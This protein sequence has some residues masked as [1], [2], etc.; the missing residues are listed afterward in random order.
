[1]APAFTP[2]PALPCPPGPCAFSLAH[3]HPPTHPTLLL[4]VGPACSNAPNVCARPPPPPPRRTPAGSHSADSR[5]S[6]AACLP[7][8]A[9]SS[10]Q[11]PA[12]HHPWCAPSTTHPLLQ[13]AVPPPP[14][15]PSRPC[16]L[17]WW[18]CWG[19]IRTGRCSAR[20]W[21][22]C[23]AWPRHA[24]VGGWWWWG[25]GRGGVRGQVGRLWWGWGGWGGTVCGSGSGGP[26]DLSGGVCCPHPPNS[27]TAHP[28]HPAAS[29]AHAC[30]HTPPSPAGLCAAHCRGLPPS[31]STTTTTT[32]TTSC[33]PSPL[34]C[35]PV[36]CPLQGPG[37][38]HLQCHPGQQRPH[39]PGGGALP[40][41]RAAG[42]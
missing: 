7:I 26:L 35:R 32:T 39:A 30:A 20:R 22:W 29:C 16:C 1:M 21:R 4:G 24:Q 23:G 13:R 12:A 3:T 42:E 5:A 37:A 38:L 34:P 2:C 8:L 18:P 27:P 11:R 19:L 6:A 15:P 31:T 14:R 40:R 28:P 41:A 9:P 25:E 36:C 33:P 10:H 17:P